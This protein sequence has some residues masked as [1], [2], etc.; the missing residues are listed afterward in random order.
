VGVKRSQSG[1]RVLSIFE[2]IAAHQPIGA[3]AL[4]KLSGED[5]SAVQRSVLTLADAGWI[6][7]APEPPV[8]WELS[9]HIFT[10]A[11]LPD[12]IL[13]L[14]QRA[15]SILDG[16]REQTGE[17]A[18]L[19]IPDGTRFVVVE[20]AESAHDLRMATRIGMIIEPH[21]SSTARAFLPYLTQT[22]QAAMLGR[23]PTQAEKEQF[24]ATLKR[25]FG[26]SA[27]DVVPGAT[28]LAVTIFDSRGEPLAVLVLSGP[29]ERL[30]TDGH[31]STGD[32]LRQAAAALSRG[33]GHAGIAR[34][35][36]DAV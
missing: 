10:I 26:L 6:R 30:P 33:R 32:L 21:Q 19:A 27:G 7:L 14:R 18:F 12:S 16:L 3:S 8:R 34:T 5:R 17:T 20:S 31:E 1:S 9:A 25:G 35:L 4:A 24:A 22:Q 28:N 23:P 15:R 2:L 11:S 13:Q 29:S 36:A